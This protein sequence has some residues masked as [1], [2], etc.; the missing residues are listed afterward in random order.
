MEVCVKGRIT[1]KMLKDIGWPE[2]LPPAR[3]DGITRL[4]IDI[5]C[6]KHK[7][8]TERLEMPMQAAMRK[9]NVL[10][11][12]WRR[13]AWTLDAMLLAAT[14]VVLTTL[15]YGCEIWEVDKLVKAAEKAWYTAIKRLLG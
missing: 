10:K 14:T 2:N 8:K 6:H 4:G 11:H 13:Q 9:T 15:T 5:S 3:T 1:P 7:G 12:M